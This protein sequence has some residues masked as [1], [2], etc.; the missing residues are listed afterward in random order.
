MIVAMANTYGM[1]RSKKR[2][3]LIIIIIKEK[4]L[5]TAACSFEAIC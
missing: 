5:M 1:L 3:G 4:P 2:T